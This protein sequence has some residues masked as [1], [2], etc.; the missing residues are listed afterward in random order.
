VELPILGNTGTIMI[1]NAEIREKLMKKII[2]EQNAY[3]A[4]FYHNGTWWTRCSAQVWNEVCFT[5]FTL[6]ADYIPNYT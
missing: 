5:F 4:P 6:L 1:K 3:S 2:S